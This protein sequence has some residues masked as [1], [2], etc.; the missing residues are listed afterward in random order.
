MRTNPSRLNAAIAAAAAAAFMTTAAIAS[1]AGATS[2]PTEPP[3]VTLTPV[4]EVGG[5]VDLAWREGDAALYVVDQYRDE[6]GQLITH[7]VGQWD[8]EATSR[9]IELQIGKDLQFVRINGTV[10]GGLVGL[11]LYTIGQLL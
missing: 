4:A 11:A 5:P 1:P 6:V 3:A 9:K 2:P 7:T 10:V 8:P